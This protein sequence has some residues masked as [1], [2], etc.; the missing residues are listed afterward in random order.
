MTTQGRVAMGAGFGLLTVVTVVAFVAF[1]AGSH[2]VSDTL[3]PF[4]LTMVPVW[5]VAIVAARLVT[6][7]RS[8]R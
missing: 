7:P 1:D 4:I 5:A 8:A 6:R 2:S 3:R